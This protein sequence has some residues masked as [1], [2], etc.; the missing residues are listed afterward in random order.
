MKL[1]TV[2]PSPVSPSLGLGMDA[3]RAGWKS[4]PGAIGLEGTERDLLHHNIQLSCHRTTSM[5]R[6]LSQADRL[7]VL[8]IGAAASQTIALEERSVAHPPEGDGA[9]WNREVRAEQGL[10]ERGARPRPA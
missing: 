4:S 6:L 7:M 2:E 3:D 9:H 1:S 8:V 5:A 10:A